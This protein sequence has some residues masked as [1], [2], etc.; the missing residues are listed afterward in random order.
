MS[1]IIVSFFLHLYFKTWTKVKC[2]LLWTMVHIDG[3]MA[4]CP[5]GV[6]AVD[7]ISVWFIS[8][9]YNFFSKC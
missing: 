4:D 8:I 3:R 7:S 1:V 6:A 9:N 2:H 5:L